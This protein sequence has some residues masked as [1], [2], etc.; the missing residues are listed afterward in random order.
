MK[1]LISFIL[2]FISLNIAKATDLVKFEGKI[3]SYEI[4]MELEQSTD[5]EN[6]IKGRY[7]YKNKTSYLSISGN[8]LGDDLLELT[9]FVGDKSTGEFYL[10][11]EEKNK[12]IGYW[13]GEKTHYDVEL[14]IVSGDITKFVHEEFEVLSASCNSDLTGSYAMETYFLNDMWLEQD[15]AV[16]IGFNGGLVTVTEIDSTKIRVKFELLC[17][18]TYHIAYFDGEVSLNSE[19]VY[20]FK[21]PFYDEEDPCHLLFTFKDKMLTIDQKSAGMNCDFGARAYADGD[22]L[23]INNKVVEG[24]FISIEAAIKLK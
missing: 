4:E 5:V 21:A 7:K 23:K 19:G 8:I 24:E 14:T 22:F 2:V 15:G 13:I 6:N 3:G 17:G 9:E 1:S 12:W 16:E 20:E 11:E 18:P 10:V